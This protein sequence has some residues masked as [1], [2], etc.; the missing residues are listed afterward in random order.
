M[1]V[2]EEQWYAEGVQKIQALLDENER[3]RN[4]IE[5]H[6]REVHAGDGFDAANE[7]LWRVL[8]A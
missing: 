5:Q 6:R 7:D 4:A 8:D 2:Q 1:R 3:L